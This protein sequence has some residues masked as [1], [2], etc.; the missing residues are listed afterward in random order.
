MSSNN[1]YIHEERVMA[2][3]NTSN[4]KQKLAQDLGRVAVHD[5]V[6]TKNKKD[7]L[8]YEYEVLS[9]YTAATGRVCREIE[10]TQRYANI[11]SQVIVCKNPKLQWYWP[12]QLVH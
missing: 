4:A 5:V 2:V 7:Q 1:E 3:E 10:I 12:R 8:V 11:T 9:E 6:K